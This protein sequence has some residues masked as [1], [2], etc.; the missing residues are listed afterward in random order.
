MRFL[1]FLIG[2]LCVSC[3]NTIVYSSFVSLPQG[4][5]KDKPAQFRFTA[6]DTLSTHDLYILLRNDYQYPY[7]NIFLI[8]KMEMPD[9][10]IIIDTLEYEMATSEGKWL[11]T[12]ASI[13]DS[14]LWYKENVKFPRKGVYHFS[15]RQADRSL[16]QNEGVKLLNGITD[17]GLQIEKRK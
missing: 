15:I 10:K 5:D 3:S 17:V 4:W 7:S 14:K 12:G 11:G 2:I 8:T 6:S 9:N 13:K 16:G 1:L